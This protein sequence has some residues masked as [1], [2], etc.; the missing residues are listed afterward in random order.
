MAKF[1]KTPHLPTP[2]TLPTLPYLSL[3]PAPCSLL[4][5]SK[6]LNPMKTNAFRLATGDQRHRA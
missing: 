5:R 3:L 1:G 6:I 4:N 2:P